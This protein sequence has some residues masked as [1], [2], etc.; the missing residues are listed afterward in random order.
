M[1]FKICTVCILEMKQFCFGIDFSE[2]PV[3]DSMFKNGY[4][5]ILELRYFA[6]N[7]LQSNIVLLGGGGRRCGEY[8]T[9]L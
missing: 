3:M 7:F 5:P 6:I 8:P 2:R 1:E 9:A 4:K